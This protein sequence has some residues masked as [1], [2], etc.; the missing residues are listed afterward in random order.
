MLPLR[1]SPLWHQPSRLSEQG[2]PLPTPPSAASPALCCLTSQ[3]RCQV[4]NHQ[5]RQAEAPHDLPARIWHQLSVQKEDDS[6]VAWSHW[7]A[8]WRHVRCKAGSCEAHS[9]EQ[10]EPFD[11][12]SIR[13][14]HCIDSLENGKLDPETAGINAVNEGQVRAWKAYA[15]SLLWPCHGN[16]AP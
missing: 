16:Y 15:S 2:L 9:Q 14:K 12:Q 6:A 8:E 4:F 10:T 5:D 7:N 3:H 1:L 13:E 11:V